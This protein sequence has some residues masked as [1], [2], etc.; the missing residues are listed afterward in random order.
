MQQARTLIL[1]YAAALGI[2]LDFQDFT[3]EMNAFP[4]DYAP[5]GGCLF[6]A[7]GDHGP[8]GCA[9]LRPLTPGVCEMRRLYVRSRHRQQGLGQRLALA[10]IAEARARRYTSMRLDTLPTMHI[11]I[12][13]YRSLGFQP[14][15]PSG[16]SAPEGALF[17]ELK[18]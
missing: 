4:A 17:F 14:A 9:G 1:E 12:G 2:H 16:T 13:L 8:G 11:A 7:T 3:R 6:I 18:L 15:A 5:P 10:V